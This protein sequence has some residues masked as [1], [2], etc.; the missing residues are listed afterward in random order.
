MFLQIVDQGDD[1]RIIYYQIG[2]YQYQILAIGDLGGLVVACPEPNIF[3]VGDE[4]YCGEFLPNNGDGIICRGIVY[5]NDFN[6][7]LDICQ[8]L[9]NGVGSVVGDNEDR[10]MC[11]GHNSS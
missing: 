11:H 8:A 3:R 2:I 4:A 6:G 1:C 7:R 5:Y 9:L 10:Y